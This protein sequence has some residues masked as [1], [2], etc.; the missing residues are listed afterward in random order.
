MKKILV[1]TDFSAAATNAAEYAVKLAKD[2]NATV[3]LL[4]AYHLPLPVSGDPSAPII[5]NDYLR[6]DSEA[7]L[8][9]DA[10]ALN[11]KSGVSVRYKVSLGLA[12][13]V[14]LEETADAD[15][16]IMGMKGADKLSEL[17]IGSIATDTLR[18]SDIPVL[19]IP[20]KVQYKKVDKIVFA[21]D[22]DPLMNINALET[23][24]DFTKAFQAKLLIVNVQDEEKLLSVKEAAVGVMVDSQFADTPHLY[25]FPS[26]D[27][28]VEEIN[29]FVKA[30]EAGMVAII[31]HRYNFFERLFHSSAS[32]KIAFH[33]QVPLLAIPEKRI[34]K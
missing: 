5:T 12:T 30:R 32:K 7:Q 27:N 10:K 24:K 4:H 18:K 11:D 20:E 28:L 15:I 31:P 21:C 34:S 33:T 8:I 9:K 19:V 23:L 13:D 25:Y 14:I 2:I 29:E 17:L 6:E 16:V 1:P 22:Y 26:G 3:L